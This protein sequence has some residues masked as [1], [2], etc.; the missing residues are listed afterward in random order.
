M[1][2]FN[3][4]IDLTKLRGTL[5]SELNFGGQVMRCVIIPI[6]KAGLFEGRKGCYLDARMVE[7]SS[8]YGDSHFIR[9]SV[10][11]NDYKAMTEEERREIPIIGN[12]KPASESSSQAPAPIPTPMPA[13]M[14]EASVMPPFPGAVNYGSPV[15]SQYGG[16]SAPAP[17]P[18]AAPMPTR[19]T[20]QPIQQLFPETQPHC[21]PHYE[22]AF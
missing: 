22:E 4:K 1:K 3:L 21:T 2:N 6:K 12:A 7:C 11:A 10:G 13:P 15:V 9:Q 19:A 14:P 18:E 8:S 17:I 5:V 16:S 20:E